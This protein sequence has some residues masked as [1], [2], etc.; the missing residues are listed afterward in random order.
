MKPTSAE[1]LAAL[2][3]GL[4]Q[5]SGIGMEVSPA[6]WAWDPVRRVILVAADDLEKRGPT[7]C[8]GVIAHEVGHYFISRY[9]LFSLPFASRMALSNLL[10]AIEDPRVNTWIKRRYPG[11]KRWLADVGDEDAW[12][13]MNDPLLDFLVFCLECAREE[14]RGWQPSRHASLARVSG[15]LEQTRHSRRAYAEWLPGLDLDASELGLDL[16]TRY[17]TEVWPALSARAAAVLPAPWEQVIRLRCWEALRLA[18]SAILPVAGRILEGDI[19]R[20]ALY[21]QGDRRRQDDAWDAINQVNRDRLTA[22]LLSARQA[23]PPLTARPPSPA[24]HTLALR[25]IDLWLLRCHR[26]PVISAERAGLPRGK[27]E[28]LPRA[29]LPPPRL[30]VPST[31]YDQAHA[32]VAS[33]INQLG[34]HLED[35]LRPRRRLRE[36]GGFASGYKLD[37]R[38]VMKFSADHRLYDRLWIRKS[39]PNRR[40][41]AVLLLL[42]L[43]GSMR[44]EKSEALLAGTVLLAETLHRLSVPFAILGFQDV[45]IPFCDFGD[46]LTAAVRQAIGQ[47]PREINGDRPRGNNKPSYNDDGPCLREAAERLLDWNATDRL[48]LVVSDGL[49]EGRS[50]NPEDLHTAVRGL[51]NVSEGLKLIGIGLGKD[52]EHVRDFYPESVA[53]VPVPQLAKEIGGMLRRS[54]LEE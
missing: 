5:D 36:A 2:A 23:S 52:T 13:A 18:D 22:L 25:L 44:G 21:L 24:L 54:L 14:L 42:D 40:N 20:L 45:L 39:I 53:N 26:I 28:P 4:C 34:R 29:P 32:R 41:A 27:A 10:N 3:A 31:A 49:P 33:Q 1:K 46:G 47:L 19:H 17:R 48:L 35:A 12:G 51:R 15:A 38:K 30:P 37:L 50:S 7:Y 9:G 11:A 8:A 43:S 16:L 6:T